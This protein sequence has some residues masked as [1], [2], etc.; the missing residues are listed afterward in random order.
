MASQE[1]DRVYILGAGHGGCVTALTLAEAGI[2]VT[3]IDKETV[4]SQGPACHLHA[5]GGIYPE[6]PDLES[7]P[8]HAISFGLAFPQAVDLRPTLVVLAPHAPWSPA[9]W[10]ERLRAGSEKYRS[11]L[12]TLEPRQRR[13]LVPEGAP[14]LEVLRTSVC[15]APTEFSP[16]GVQAAAWLPDE[17]R[18]A[19]L[20]WEAG[21]NCIRLAGLLEHSLAKAGPL[22]ELRLGTAVTS[23]EPDG[24][25]E[26]DG[27]SGRW[28]LMLEG[29]DGVAR[30]EVAS[31]V[32]DARG[33][34]S[35]AGAPAEYK[36]VFWADHPT[37]PNEPEVVVL[38]RRGGPG[39]T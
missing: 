1:H 37:A 15:A 29:A 5:F 39:L 3:L 23:L 2:P 31:A 18:D 38:D 21:I 8:E 32:V 33:A 16:W 27:A 12:D 25:A 9:A 22:I 28:R 19:V 36:C 30:S 11:L 34:H 4:V 6:M 17:A 13:A 35:A 24:E 26:G 14:I 20:I 7:L 10:H